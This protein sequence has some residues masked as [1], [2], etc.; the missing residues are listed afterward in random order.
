LIL[1]DR[2]MKTRFKI[3]DKHTTDKP[4]QNPLLDTGS[5]TIDQINQQQIIEGIKKLPVAPILVPAGVAEDHTPAYLI[6]RYFARRPHNVFSYLINHYSNPGNIILDPFMGGGVTIIESLRL[7]RKVIG[8][9]VN[10]LAWFVSREEV[11]DVD[12]IA[13]DKVFEDIKEKVGNKVNSFYKT[14]C[15]ICGNSEAIA[16][17]YEWSDVVLC[18]NC[19]NKQ[20]LKEAKKLASKRKRKMPTILL[21]RTEDEIDNEPLSE[22]LYECANPKCKAVLSTSTCKVLEN[23]LCTVKVNCS[24]CKS[25]GFKTHKTPSKFDLDQY[26]KIMKLSTQL[27]SKLFYPK[28][29]IPSGDET[30]RLLKRHYEYWWQLFTPR[31]LLALSLLFDYV[32]KID[33]IE[34]KRIWALVLSSSLWRISKFAYF[35]SDGRIVNAGHH[36]WLP[37]IPAEMN[38]WYYLLKRRITAVR[39]GK[40][41]SAQ[42]IG[43]FYQEAKHVEE[44]DD[45]KTCLLLNQ[46]STTLPL[47]NKTVDVVITDPPFGG[48]VN[49]GELSD[50][51]TVWLKDIVGLQYGIADKTKEALINRTQNKGE[52]E[53]ED[54]LFGIFKECHRVLKVD[55]WMVLTFHNRD[56]KVWM[57]LHRAALRAGFRLPSADE[58][59]NRGIVYQPPIAEHTTTLHQQ[60]AGAMLGDFILSFKRQDVV[61]YQIVSGVLSTN[62]EQGLKAKTE[63]LIHFHGGADEST[64]MTGLIPYLGEQNLF[65][66]LVG[67]DF[68]SFFAKFFV[69]DKQSKKWFTSDMIDP[70]TKTLKP[71]DYVPAEHLTE[72][73][74]YSYLKTKKYAS[75][76]EILTVIYTQ[77][78]NSHRP[79]TTA[80]GKVLDK[81]CD[82]VPLPNSPHHQGFAL[83]KKIPSVSKIELPIVVEQK[84]LFGDYVLATNLGHDDI[85]TLLHSYASK[86]GFDGHIG[87][88]EQDKNPAFK[89]ISRQ[90]TTSEEFGLPPSV[91]NTI[92]EIDLLLLK[93]SLITHAI[94]VATTVETADKAINNRYRNLFVAIPNLTIR[95]YVVVKDKDFGKAYSIV[96]SKANVQE[97]ISQKIKIIRLSELTSDG[98]EKIIK[99]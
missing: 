42:Q 69:Y 5:S 96:F 89:K 54:L 62:E 58:S 16:E 85:I 98:F 75:L 23:R 91:F 25:R 92:C 49:Y 37:D 35:K 64:L 83:K 82:K 94:E 47:I 20:V 45:S 90:M 68:N 77:L 72:Q 59:V 57:S 27:L 29:A 32:D 84:S 3:K 6:H 40:Q 70:A 13:F 52:Q 31:N 55:A 63:E 22:H 60:A 7:K 21:H 36:F 34:Q 51:C 17:W 46:S 28:D 78:V 93:G 76:D 66:K 44:L 43:S 74:I 39:G 50:F 71:L 4:K 14:D 99:A 24:K 9:D 67:V 81:L 80:I 1:S 38:V 86:M 10:P 97:G 18:P 2:A 19:G 87:N 41:Y 79:G 65:H 26:N 33:D 53:Y 48:N 56:P 15:H 88:T 73:I 11:A 12:L 95:A 8:V 61:P 30:E